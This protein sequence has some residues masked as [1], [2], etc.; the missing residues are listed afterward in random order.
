MPIEVGIWK[1][2]DGVKKIECSSIESERRLEDT[3]AKD[4]S[5]LSEDLLLIGRQVKTDYNKYIDMLA[6]DQDGNLVIIEL[7]KNKTPRDVVAQSIDY[8]SWVEQLSYEQVLSIFK[9]NNT[10]EIAEAFGEKFNSSLPET[11]NN[12]H[13]I[14]IV[15]TEL[16][17]A[18]ERIIQ[19]LSHNFDVPINAVYFRYFEESGHQFLVRNWLIDPR[20]VDEKSSAIK[21]KK[22]EKWNERDYVVNFEESTW[23]NWDDAVK[24]GFVAAGGGR[25]Y[26]ITLKKVPVGARIFCMVPGHGYVGIGKVVAAAKPAKDMVFLEYD[27][28]KKIEALDLRAPEMLHD[29]DDEDKQEYIA[30]VEWIATVPVKNAYWKRGF[31]ANQHVAFKLKDQFTIDQVTKHFNI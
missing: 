22:Q 7:K 29:M 30:K 8:A 19:Y 24:Y 21:K 17:S 3:L 20:I 5:I 26:S 16:D 18:T 11:I 25:R 15:S 4:I 9:H 1:V 28:E 27:K 2:N 23:R 10:K 13:Q 31:A 12:E 6:I 14:M